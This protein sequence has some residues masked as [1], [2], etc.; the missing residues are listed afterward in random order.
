M[1]DDQEAYMA[2]LIKFILGVNQGKAK[3]IL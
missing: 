2:G 1:Y 3:S